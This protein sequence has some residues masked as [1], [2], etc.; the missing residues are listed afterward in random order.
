M[1]NGIWENRV[2]EPLIFTHPYIYKHLIQCGNK[3]HIRIENDQRLTMEGFWYQ[4]SIGIHPGVGV[5]CPW[6]GGEADDAEG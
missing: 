2:L 6:G 3:M 1:E 5:N 4:S